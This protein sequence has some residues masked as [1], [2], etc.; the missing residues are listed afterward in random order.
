[1]LRLAF[2][3][4]FAVLTATSCLIACSVDSSTDGNDGKFHP[5]TNGQPISED[6]ACSSLRT[7][8]DS[9]RSTL[10][11]TGT[12]RT[13]PSLVQVTAG[14]MCAQ[15]DQGTIQGCADY[16]QKAADCADLTTRM[17]NCVYVAIANSA[18][19]GCPAP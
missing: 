3:R 14:A 12:T 4:L 7:A 13:C 10:Q 2:P 18:P 9:A 11:C 1:V 16:Y 15:Y 6:E 8:I 5:P 17:D 19:K